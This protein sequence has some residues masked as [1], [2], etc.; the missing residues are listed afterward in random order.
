LQFDIQYYLIITRKLSYRQDDR[1]MRPY[2]TIV[3]HQKW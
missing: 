1:A 3:L 2:M